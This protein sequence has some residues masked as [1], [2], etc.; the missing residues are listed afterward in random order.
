MGCYSITVP[1]S[2]SW[3]EFTDKIRKQFDLASDAQLSLY[4]PS[5]TQQQQEQETD[6]IDLSELYKY[7]IS[8]GKM[9]KI[10][11]QNV[12][13]VQVH[14]NESNKESDT[15]SISSSSHSESEQKENENNKK[16]MDINERS[17]G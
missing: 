1:A 17:F 9:S 16:I 5:T 6:I 2:K 13:C 12:F 10:K 8:D 14:K 4:K 7:D 3:T 11:H 15:E